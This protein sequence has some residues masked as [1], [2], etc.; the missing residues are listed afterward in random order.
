V[1]EVVAREDRVEVEVVGTSMTGMAMGVVGTMVMGMVV[2]GA[3]GETTISFM[4]KEIVCRCDVRDDEDEEL[5]LAA[6][7]SVHLQSDAKR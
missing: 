7:T 6:G 1:A 5:V 4:M 2:V 3:R